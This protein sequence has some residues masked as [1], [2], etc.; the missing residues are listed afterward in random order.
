MSRHSPSI[1]KTLATGMCAGGATA[2]QGHSGYFNA[3]GTLRGGLKAN[4]RSVWSITTK[5]FKEAHFATFPKDLVKP[6]ILAGSQ[7]NDIVLDPFMGA[8]TVAVVAKNLGRFFVGI[9][10]SEKYCRIAE[11]RLKRETDQT[12]MFLVK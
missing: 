10:L 3:N 6:C 2:S 8:A 9:E 5:P 7:M 12:N 11:E 4:K 1:G